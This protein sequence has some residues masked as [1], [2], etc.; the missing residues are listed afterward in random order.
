LKAALLLRQRKMV[1]I[2]PFKLDNAAHSSAAKAA[3]GK[4]A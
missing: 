2:R 1:E 3:R 4:A